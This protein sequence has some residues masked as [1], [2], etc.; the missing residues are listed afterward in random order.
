MGAA[1]TGISVD[2]LQAQQF[3]LQMQQFQAEAM[4]QQAM[5]MMQAAAQRNAEA[6]ERAQ[7]CARQMDGVAGSTDRVAALR[8]TGDRFASQRASAHKRQEAI[9]ARIANRESELQ[10]RRDR[11]AAGR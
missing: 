2:A 3:M 1:A 4:R 7:Q 6:G 8:E 11:A 5:Q 9:A 10:R